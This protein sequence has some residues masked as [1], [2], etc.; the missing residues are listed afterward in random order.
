GRIAFVSAT[1]AVALGL[2]ATAG[3]SRWGRATAIFA[4][5]MAVGAALIWW[6]SERVAAPRLDRPGLMA[7]TGAVETM[8]AL[9]APRPATRIVVI[10]EGEGMP[11]RL[12]IT[13]REG[14]TPAG[15]A[16]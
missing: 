7:F 11:A 12:R 5:A 10:P 16:P 8:Q 4:L 13:I 9:A 2:A 1:L 15:L 14:Q 6:Q 3:A